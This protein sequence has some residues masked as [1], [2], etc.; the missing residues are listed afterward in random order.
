MA[1]AVIS[2]I[3][4]NLEALNRALEFIEKKDDIGDVIILGDI[5][6]YG[7]NPNECITLCKEVSNTVILGNHDKAAY[8]K[9]T[10]SS[11]NI[12]AVR[13]AEW[14]EEN[15]EDEHIIFLKNLPLTIKRERF[16]FVHSSPHNPGGWLYISGMFDA[17]F[18]L[19]VFEQSICFI[20]H[21]HIPKIFTEGEI[22]EIKNERYYLSQEEKYIIN[23]GSIGQPRDRN[24]DLSFAIFNEIEWSVEYVRL[25]YN[26]KKA[27]DK[28]ID[29]GLP[30]FLSERLYT[31]Y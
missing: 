20:G 8:D 29:A 2:D 21:T 31:G 16:L 3:H 30:Q 28:I 26:I 13:S 24:P 11:F 4:S 17:Q 14:T 6:G 7:A 22:P 15:L 19:N 9:E 27:A 23:V 5:V 1:F 12:N 10:R 18:Q 25:D